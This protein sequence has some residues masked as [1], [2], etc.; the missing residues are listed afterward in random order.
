MS[1]IQLY[2]RKSKTV[3]EE[4][5]FEKQ[6]IDF[7]YGNKF[8]LFLTDLILKKAFVSKI[9]GMREN[10][11]S[12]KKRI[13]P[14]IEKYKIN[15]DEILEPLESFKTFNE[16]FTRK[17]IPS[18]REVDMNKNI[19]ISPADAR[20]LAY[21]IEKNTVIPV[22]GLRFTLNELI[23]DESVSKNYNKGTCLVFR[24]APVDYHRFIYIDNGT[25]EEIKQLG[26]DFHSVNPLALKNKFPVFQKNYREYCVLKTANFGDVIHVDVGALGVGKII[27]NNREKSS[28]LKGEEKGYFEF[29]ASTIILIFKPSMVR[30]DKDIID[31]SKKGI[32]TIVKCGSSIG[33]KK[34][35]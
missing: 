17:L 8:G 26:K 15:T 18:A 12:S 32:E 5:V 13:K 20:L 30:M 9:L 11:S 29:G 2:N 22:K 28:F 31:F 16:F 4:I 1:K 7:F 33:E 14:F 34:T 6:F 35:V 25:H 23:G 27:Q 21:K 24:L 10:L 3:E 19:L